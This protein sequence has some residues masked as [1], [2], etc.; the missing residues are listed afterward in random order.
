MQHSKGWLGTLHRVLGGPVAPLGCLESQCRAY[1]TLEL[2]PKEQFPFI[3][4]KQAPGMGCAM[5]KAGWGKGPG[6]QL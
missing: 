5:G 1:S 6:L 2:G 4:R 3:P